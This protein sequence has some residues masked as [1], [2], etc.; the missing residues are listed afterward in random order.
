M[1]RVIAILLLSVTAAI[2][3]EKTTLRKTW[4][5]RSYAT[6]AIP[7]AWRPANIP[8]TLTDV[9]TFEDLSL[10]TE[11]LSIQ[12][13]IT[14]FGLPNRYL[15]TSKPSGQDFLIYDLPSGHAVALYAAK[16][17]AEEFAACAIITS[18]GSLVRLIK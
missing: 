16:P 13:F 11:S 18:D 7:A 2:A 12:K 8:P 10:R 17:P 4:A 9:G 6:N 3:A 1:L 15:A 14:R 5:S